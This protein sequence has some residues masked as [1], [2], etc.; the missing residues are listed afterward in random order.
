MSYSRLGQTQTT[1]TQTIVYRQPQYAVAPILYSPGVRFARRS[2]TAGPSQLYPIALNP[3]EIEK[4]IYKDSPTSVKKAQEV[5]G[6]EPQKVVTTKLGLEVP[7]YIIQRDIARK[8]EA[9]RQQEAVANI[10]LPKFHKIGVF[11]TQKPAQALAAALVL[12]YVSGHI[13]YGLRH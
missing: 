7:A 12:G 5:T 9:I 3:E 11:A 4:A 6:T 2:D 8:Q 13:F 10:P 1:T